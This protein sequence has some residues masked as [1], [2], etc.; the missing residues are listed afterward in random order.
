MLSN[1]IVWQE[2][3]LLDGAR[4]LLKFKLAY[5]DDFFIKLMI[6][7]AKHINLWGNITF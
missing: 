7:A 5:R 2:C 6:I 4:D 3:T 1:D